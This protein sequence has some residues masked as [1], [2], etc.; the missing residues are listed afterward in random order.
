MAGSRVTREKGIEGLCYVPLV[1]PGQLKS[2]DAEELLRNS[3]PLHGLMTNPSPE[4][5]DGFFSSSRSD[6][7]SE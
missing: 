4:K 1:Y 2:A 5:P 6:D 3:P 7:R